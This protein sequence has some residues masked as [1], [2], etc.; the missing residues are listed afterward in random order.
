[1]VVTQAAD[2]VRHQAPGLVVNTQ[3]APVGWP[4]A[5]SARVPAVIWLDAPLVRILGDLRRELLI[6]QRT[7]RNCP[8]GQHRKAAL[9]QRHVDPSDVT[10]LR[11][12]AT[13]P[14]TSVTQH[15]LTQT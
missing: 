12:H 7:D 1:M 13:E 9:A 4:S 14:Q 11:H 5:Q 10:L 2:R 6:H 15:S 3:A 8:L